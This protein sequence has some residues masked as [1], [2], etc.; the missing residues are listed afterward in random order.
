MGKR[1]GFKVVSIAASC[2]A[3]LLLMGNAFAAPNSSNVSVPPKAVNFATPLAGF[4]PLTASASEL[5]RYGLPEK[6]KEGTKAYD[7]WA[8]AVKS[9][10]KVDVT[11]EKIGLEFGAVTS[12]VN[13]VN[14][15]GYKVTTARTYTKAVGTTYVPTNVSN[16]T[17]TATWAG[18]TNSA[19]NY[20]IQAGA[21]DNEPGSS[22]P[23]FWYENYPDAAYKLTGLTA[24]GGDKYYVSVGYN[25]G[26]TT[27]S[28]YISNITTGSYS[29][30][31]IPVNY[32][33]NS[34]TEYILENPTSSVGY[35]N[36][37]NIDMTGSYTYKIGTSVYTET[38]YSGTEN[39]TK[40]IMKNGTSTYYSP[41][42]INSSGTFTNLK[43]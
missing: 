41:Q 20:I 11:V 35:E 7:N 2:L 17:S 6:P 19:N 24:H 25:A 29:S 12:T 31:S 5:E 14:Y 13:T 16:S 28:I 1:R 21:C 18:L 23:F 39:L 26:E 34:A 22:T 3:S 30:I 32:P 43:Y 37:G 15:S 4:N 27:A 33:A 40:F 36:V 9:K 38:V 8:E 10:N 42:T